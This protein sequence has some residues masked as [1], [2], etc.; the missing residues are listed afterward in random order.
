MKINAILV[1]LLVPMMAAAAADPKILAKDNELDFSV[2]DMPAFKALGTEPSK[3]LRPS[4]PE[5]FAASFSEFF[6]GSEIVVPKAFA[7]EF[8]PA[9]LAK[10]GDLTLREYSDRQRLYGVRVSIG[11]QRDSAGSS[12]IAVGIRLPIID[13]GNPKADK[14]FLDKLAGILRH[15]RQKREAYIDIYADSLHKTDED[16]ANDTLLKKAA[17]AYAEKRLA[18][19]T[20]TPGGSDSAIALERKRYVESHWNAE[21][22]ELAAALVDAAEDSVLED[23]RFR[24]ASF[25]LSYANGIGASGQWLLSF[26][27]S[28]IKE[29][30]RDEPDFN[31]DLNS[32]FYAGRNQLK[33]F[34]QLEAGYGQAENAL[35]W[36]L[37]LG[38]E[39]S[40]GSGI[41]VE[42]QNG[43]EWFE[44]GDGAGLRGDLNLKWNIAHLLSAA[45]GG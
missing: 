36:A 17:L 5:A 20:L 26:H 16:L 33:A 29:K 24:S 44:G 34:G 23:V 22:L 11:T 15:Q 41:W 43:V 7:A 9:L 13:A 27:I 31:V 39:F 42:F 4:D 45:K 37:S 12:L 35:H 8:S 10:Y 2:P 30:S 25:W 40:L 32:R 19:D 28:A 18:S 1:L 3:V 6:Q 14:A 38:G 21:K